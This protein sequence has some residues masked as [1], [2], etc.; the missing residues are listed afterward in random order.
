MLY[1]CSHMA[2]VGVK[3]LNTHLYSHVESNSVGSLEFDSLTKSLE[4]LGHKPRAKDS[5]MRL[6][7]YW[8]NTAE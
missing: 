8:H 1:S 3:W 2:T 4:L 6:T 5:L 7:D